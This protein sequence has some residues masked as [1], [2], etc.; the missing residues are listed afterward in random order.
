MFSKVFKIRSGNL[1]LLHAMS[2]AV[3]YGNA[4]HRTPDKSRL[5]SAD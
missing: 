5:E 2:S 3:V 4:K 1:K